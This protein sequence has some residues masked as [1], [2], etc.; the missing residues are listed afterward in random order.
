M[1]PSLIWPSLAQV[2]VRVTIVKDKQG[3][4]CSTELG[5]IVENIMKIGKRCGIWDEDATFIFCNK[6]SM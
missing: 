4:A 5:Y 2:R 1:F 3:F 6:T